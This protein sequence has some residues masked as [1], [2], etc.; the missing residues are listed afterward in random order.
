MIYETGLSD[1]PE[2]LRVDEAKKCLCFG[3]KWPSD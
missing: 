3:A 2:I 1:V